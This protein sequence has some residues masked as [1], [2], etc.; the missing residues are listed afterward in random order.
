M[1]LCDLCVGFAWGNGIQNVG[2]YVSTDTGARTAWNSP[3]QCMYVCM[4]VCMYA[5]FIGM[6]MVIVHNVDQDF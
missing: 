5:V 2:P 1:T 3:D 4:Y 6:G